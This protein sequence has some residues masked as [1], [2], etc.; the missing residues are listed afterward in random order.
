MRVAVVGANGQV[1]QTLVQAFA[2][3]G[4]QVTPLTHA[5]IEIASLESVRAC[6]TALRA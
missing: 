3:R 1:G 5:E 4:D 6:L 2:E